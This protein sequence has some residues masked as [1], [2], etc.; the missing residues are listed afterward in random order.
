MKTLSEI[1]EYLRD[2]GTDGG[3]FGGFTGRGFQLQQRIDELAPFLLF[4][5]GETIES[6]FEIG[7]AQGGLSRVL[8]EFCKPGL[9]VL[10]D[11]NS[12]DSGARHRVE[13]LRGVPHV[14]FIGFAED[15]R[16]ADAGLRLAPEGYSLV[17]IDGDHHSPSPLRDFDNYK[18]LVKPGGLLFFHDSAHAEGVKEAVAHISAY[19]SRSWEKVGVFEKGQVGI[20]VFRRR[21]KEG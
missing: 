6:V 12:H 15:P 9:L 19:H 1:E 21:E 17:V 8:Y 20:T 2:C 3:V 7:A 16:F 14:E 13:N 10:L 18:H 4:I 11:N 5:Q